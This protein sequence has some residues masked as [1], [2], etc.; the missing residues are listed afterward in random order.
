ML[1]SCWNVLSK[2]TAN[3]AEIKMTIEDQLNVQ[4]KWNLHPINPNPD[5]AGLKDV[6]KSGEESNLGKTGQFQM[7]INVVTNPVQNT[8]VIY[9]ATNPTLTRGTNIRYGV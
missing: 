8:P 1:Q 2:R 9:A 4:R 5:M 7:E 3:W 6:Y